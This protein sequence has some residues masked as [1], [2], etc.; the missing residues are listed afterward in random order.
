MR[1]TFQ[2]FFGDKC[3]S[4]V[5][6]M[7]CAANIG[8]HLP[9]P[10]ACRMPTHPNAHRSQ[11]QSS[12]GAKRS[13]RQGALEPGSPPHGKRPYRRPRRRR[14]LRE[15]RRVGAQHAPHLPLSAVRPVGA[16]RSAA[17]ADV[18]CRCGW[19]SLRASSAAPRRAASRESR[20]AADKA[21]GDCRRVLHVACCM[22]HVACCMLCVRPVRIGS[23]DHPCHAHARACAA[24]GHASLRERCARRRLGESLDHAAARGSRGLDC[25]GGGVCAAGQSH[26]RTMAGPVPYNGRPSAATPRHGMQCA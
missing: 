18:H 14:P 12:A 25:S 11:G 26:G 20:T 5:R 2:S 17:S 19:P 10:V 3:S 6:T 15:H 8:T 4:Y 7:C 23:M 24:H 1:R 13:S 9:S 16:K 21:D 22:L